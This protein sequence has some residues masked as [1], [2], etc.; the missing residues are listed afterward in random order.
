MGTGTITTV[1]GTG[2]LGL[3]GEGGR[4]TNASLLFPIG[5]Y[6][7]RN[8]NIYFTD[9]FSRVRGVDANGILR[10]VAGTTRGYSGDGGPADTAQMDTPRAVVSDESG[11]LYVADTGNSVI[12]KIDARG[13]IRTIA[14]TNRFGFSGDGGPATAA[15]LNFPSDLLLD[16]RGGL[17]IADLENHRVRRLELST[18]I[19]TTFAGNG[20]TVYSGD[21]GPALLA[22]IPSPRG[23]AR[24]ATGNIYVSGDY[25]VR[26]IDAATGIVRT[27]VGNNT[28]GS[29]GDGGLAVLARLCE[30]QGLLVDAAGNLLIADGGNNRIRRVSATAPVPTLVVAPESIALTASDFSSEVVDTIGA[31]STSNLAS[32]SWTATVDG[33]SWLSVIPASGV[34]PGV[35]RVLAN[36][37]GLAPGTYSGRISI[38]AAGALNSPR[39]IPVSL[40]VSPSGSSRLA[41]D[42]ASLTLRALRGSSSP[43]ATFELRNTGG[44]LLD[45]TATAQTAAGA[46]WLSVSPARGRGPAT[47]TVTAAAGALSA[48]VYEGQVRLADSGGGEPLSVPVVLIVSEAAPALALGQTGIQMHAAEGASFIPPASIEVLNTGRSQMSWQARAQYVA[49]AGPS[50]L[51]LSTAS[52][53]IAGPGSAQLRLFASPAGLRAGTYDALVTVAAAG[54]VNSP[55]TVLVRLRVEA[56]AQGAVPGITPGGLLFAT[57]PGGGVQQ[58]TITLSSSGGSPLAFVTSANAGAARPGG[59][60]W[61]SVSPP[62]GILLGSSEQARLTVQVNP[63]GLPAGVHEGTISLGFGPG[64]NR[65]VPVLLVV[66]TAAAATRESGDAGPQAAQ[67]R[68]GAVCT[69]ARQIPVHTAVLN[70]FEL[71]V[72]WP[73]PILASV[74]DDCG[75][76]VS[77]STLI[78]TLSTGDAAIPLQPLGGGLY[79]GMWTPSRAGRTSLTLVATGSSLQ[80]GRS[81]AVIGNV[82]AARDLGSTPLVFRNGA[83]HAAT[84][85]Q[86]APL[87][88]GQIIS[89]FGR[90]LARQPENAQQVPL[91]RTLA[92]LTARLGDR[93]LPLYFVGNGQVNAQVPADLAPG[94][95]LPLTVTVGGTASP[96]ELVTLSRISP[97]IFSVDSSGSGPALAFDA[98]GGLINS[99]NPAAHGDVVVLFTTGLGATNPAV[100]S[101]ETA[102]SSPL[103]R[104]VD[105]VRVLFGGVAAET[106]FAGLTPG[107]VGLYQVNVRIPAGAPAGEAVEIY[108]EQNQATSN[109]VM[110]AI[111]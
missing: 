110:L 30:S 5:L 51:S 63:A 80:A 39:T 44:S 46:A 2:R 60:G 57:T 108:L 54:A 92:G 85:R 52:G 19:I 13:V 11:N 81:L 40:S 107:F 23:L 86:H 3:Q 82:G 38:A 21:G 76:P 72:G 9:N 77:A 18:G 16:G 94:Q 99:G 33:G 22:G 93:D 59:P 83:V 7:D 64:L 25:V 6:V 12:R 98:H 68:D 29:S 101:G 47:V 50:W 89:I 104:V 67:L 79:S 27:V 53:T 66:T 56:A 105:P 37:A 100:P 17:L 41:V 62:G 35:V 26:R 73:T 15:M 84:F 90:N 4:A 106:E 91:P 70:N 78:C 71:P 10:T 97:G 31:I 34:T 8:N 102:P 103:A 109:R 45:W 88:P 74:V 49:A 65:D 48:G 75:A 20:T 42:R 1:A 43:P 58:N 96:P 14:G 36:P 32:A 111:R 61:L 87:A 69:P 55:Q 24:D 95:V 28:L